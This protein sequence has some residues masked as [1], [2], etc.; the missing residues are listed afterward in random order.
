MTH[1]LII[2]QSGSGK[3]IVQ[4]RIL[5][6]LLEETTSR[7]LD[8]YLISPLSREDSILNRIES[9]K[10][11]VGIDRISWEKILDEVYKENINR[12]EFLEKNG[13]ESVDSYNNDIKNKR[14]ITKN[15]YIYLDKLSVSDK[16]ER[17]TKYFRFWDEIKTGVLMI[18]EFH[19]VDFFENKNKLISLL[20]QS[21]KANI[22]IIIC[23]QDT[24][25]SFFKICSKNIKTNIILKLNS[26]KSEST[27]KSKISNLE[28]ATFLR[29]YWECLLFWNC[30][31]WKTKFSID[32]KYAIR[33]NFLYYSEL[34]KAIEIH[35]HKSTFINKR[36]R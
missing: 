3:T 24:S 33:W 8:L 11:P 2:W 32:E 30:F 1:L 35:N 10:V 14:I 4:N 21:R 31:M 25:S 15:W 6:N 20:E 22:H 18:D 26:I 17:D 5:W 9:L 13:Y 16:K 36:N 34:E 7:T 27:L 12:Y 28:E 29:G 23:V 19:V